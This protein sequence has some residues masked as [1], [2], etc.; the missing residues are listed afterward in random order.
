MSAFFTLHHSFC[1]SLQTH[2]EEIAQFK[3]RQIVLIVKWFV[4]KSYSHFMRNFWSLT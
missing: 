2:F 1:Q 3:K 4:M